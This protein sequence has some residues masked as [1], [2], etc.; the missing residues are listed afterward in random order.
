M[1]MKTPKCTIYARST[2]MEISP[3]EKRQEGKPRE[4]RISLRFFR[5][6]GGTPQLRFVAEPWEGFELSRM[7]DRVSLEGGKQT[8]T[9]KFEGSGGETVTR[10]SV[11]KYERNGKGGHAMTI[12]RGDDIINVTVALGQFLY[13]GEFLRRLSV[14]ESWVE[15][16]ESEKGISAAD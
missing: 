2:G 13:A 10:L 7:I 1:K 12:Q 11:E 5:M 3:Y 15:Q 4:G 14:T 9:H 16:H 6:K 8:L